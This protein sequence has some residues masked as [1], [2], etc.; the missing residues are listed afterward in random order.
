MMSRGFDGFPKKVSLMW[1]EVTIDNGPQLQQAVEVMRMCAP[2][3]QFLTTN[4]ILA[5]E[6]SAMLRGEG[7]LFYYT[8]EAFELV[9]TVNY[10]PK[11]DRHQVCYAVTGTVSAQSALDLIVNKTQEY[12]VSRG[13]PYVYGCRPK[14]QRSDLLR[15]IY[16]LAAV[17]EHVEETLLADLDDVWVYRIAYRSTARA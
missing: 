2:M 7:R 15:Q 16:D 3:G 17:D 10:Q 4:R 14:Y 8:G 11:G 5:S 9:V 1:Q 6:R 12:M 13:I